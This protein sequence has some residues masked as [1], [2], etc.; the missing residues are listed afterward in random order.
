M[1]ENL[2]F[3]DEASVNLA[4]VRLYARALKGQRARGERPQKRGVNISLLSAL[5]LRGVVA[6]INIYGPVDGLTFEAFTVRKVVPKLWKGACVVIDNAKIH[7]GEMVKD[8]IESAGATLIYLSP[9]SP[10]FSPIENFW[11]KVK[12]I[13]RKLKARTYAD[14]IDAITDAMLQVTQT[15]IRRVHLS[16]ANVSKSVKLKKLVKPSKKDEIK[17]MTPQDEQQLKAHL[18]AAAEILYKN[19]DPAALKSFE[20]IEKSLREQILKEVGPELASFF[21][22]KSQKLK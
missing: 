17:K 12:A 7:F 6:S 19:T 4:M 11:S 13:L 2:I 22:Q 5:S 1:A 8:S 9:Y 21:F 16:F 20:D 15:D 14:L 3:M 18:K 10:E